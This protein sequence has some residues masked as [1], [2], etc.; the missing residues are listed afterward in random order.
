[1]KKLGYIETSSL[2]S[3]K[4]EQLQKHFRE[5]AVVCLSTDK[6]FR[7]FGEIEENLRPDH[8]LGNYRDNPY[9]DMLRKQ[10]MLVRFIEEEYFRKY[11]NSYCS[12]ETV[13][14]YLDS[15]DDL[16]TLDE[17]S[18]LEEID[19]MI[20]TRMSLQDRKSVV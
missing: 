14:E 7:A 10:Y 4:K 11:G 15:I 13:K 1:M 18:C 20:L 5:C 3:S 2:T 8:N 19:K 9:F 12:F 17:H 6:V 16:R